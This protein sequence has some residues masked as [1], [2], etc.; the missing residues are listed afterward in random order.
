MLPTLVVLERT[1]GRR[2]SV[3]L[4]IGDGADGRAEMV[5]ARGEP[6]IAR[7]VALTRPPIAPVRKCR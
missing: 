5:V 1:V 4:S 6:S 3:C 2:P 7:E